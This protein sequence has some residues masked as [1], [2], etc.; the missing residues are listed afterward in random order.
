[1]VFPYI[2]RPQIER[3][4]LVIRA[5]FLVQYSQI[6]QDIGQ[7]GMLGAEGLL[8]YFERANIQRL[9][10]CIG[11]LSDIELCDPIERGGHVWVH[12]AERRLADV[13]SPEVE[14]LC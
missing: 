3:F 10:L 4:R 9:R 5:S 13:E 11:I 1:M 14:R 8:E 12:P 2:Q 6:V 7:F